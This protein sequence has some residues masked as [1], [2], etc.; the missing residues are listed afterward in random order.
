MKRKILIVVYIL[1]IGITLEWIFTMVTNSRI[2]SN[3][4]KG[5]YLKNQAKVL[6]YLKFPQ[7]YVASYNYGNILYQMGEYE[8]AIEEYNKAL[9]GI[10]PKEKECSIRV[11]VKEQDQDSIK[12]AIKTYESAIDLLTQNGCAGK[13]DMAGHSQKA[14]QLKKD[15][16]KEIDRLK[17]KLDQEEDEQDKEN[18]EEQQEK[19]KENVDPIEEKLQDIK[20]D[21]IKDQREVEN[22][23]KQY[24]RDED[25][26]KKNW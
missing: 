20:K 12:N 17:Q 11:E 9:E 22:Q 2:V 19:K 6:T 10:V 25:R 18:Q 3:Y 7:K 26:P 5:N 16:Q 21:A 14:E 24:K 8:E 15:I 4:H 1:L 13:E 23:Y